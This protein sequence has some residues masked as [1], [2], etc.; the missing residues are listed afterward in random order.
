[1]RPTVC[2]KRLPHVNLLFRELSVWGSADISFIAFLRLD[3]R[4]FSRHIFSSP[5]ERDEPFHVSF[6]Q[7]GPANRA[8][9]TPQKSQT[10]EDLLEAHFA[11][12]LDRLK[13][14]S[15]SDPVSRLNQTLQNARPAGRIVAPAY[16]PT[17]S[18]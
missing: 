7:R 10:I 3:Q 15:G 17:V 12:A 13:L 18:F 2:C 1:M 14:Q 4:A 16:F 11:G 5:M 6:S 8:V 9:K